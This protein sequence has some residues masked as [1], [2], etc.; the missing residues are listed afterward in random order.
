MAI[1]AASPTLDGPT[2]VVS[3]TGT[4]EAPCAGADVTGTIT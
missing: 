2:L 4:T 1:A 3:F